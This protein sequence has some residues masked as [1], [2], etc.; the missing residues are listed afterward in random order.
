MHLADGIP[1]TIL[2]RAICAGVLV[3]QGLNPIAAST[4]PQS[5][6]DLTCAKGLDHDGFN[7]GRDGVII[8]ISIETQATKL[9][10]N[11]KHLK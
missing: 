8:L 10:L 1:T 4:L 7:Q 11:L 9:S 5:T 3:A 6:T 2:P